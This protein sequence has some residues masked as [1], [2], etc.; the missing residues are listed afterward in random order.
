MTPQERFTM[1]SYAALLRSGGSYSQV[2]KFLVKNQ[3]HLPPEIYPL[4]LEL[5]GLNLATVAARDRMEI[6]TQ[7]IYSVIETKM[8]A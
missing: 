3:P 7:K 6:I 4:I 8:A 2:S 1:H 5:T